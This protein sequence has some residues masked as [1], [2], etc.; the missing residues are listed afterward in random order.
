[1]SIQGKAVAREKLQV[2]PDEPQASPEPLSGWN[3]PEA[4][5]YAERHSRLIDKKFREG[6]SEEE[7]QELNQINKIMDEY[8]A[9]F[10]KPIIEKLQAIH[11]QLTQSGLPRS[12]TK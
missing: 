9:P 2:E 4:A 10:Y 7:A 5:S 11:E 12:E 6:L 3:S 1:M 8:D